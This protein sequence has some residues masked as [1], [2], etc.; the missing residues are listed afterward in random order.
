[1]SVGAW[2][3]RVLPKSTSESHLIPLLLRISLSAHSG[4]VL[5]GPPHRIPLP[6]LVGGGVCG[7]GDGD[8]D[9]GG[10]GTGD[11]E[12]GLFRI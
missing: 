4:P 12:R 8:G 7:D 1:M 2:L 11:T 10:G 6:G 3:S 5:W 9:G